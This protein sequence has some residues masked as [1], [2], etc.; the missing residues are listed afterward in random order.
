MAREDSNDRLFVYAWDVNKNESKWM[1]N[2]INNGFRPTYSTELDQIDL[3][4]K[5]GTTIMSIP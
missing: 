2:L 1:T 5:F 3:G 4:G